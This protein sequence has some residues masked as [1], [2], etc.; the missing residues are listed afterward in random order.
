VDASGHEARVTVQTQDSLIEGRIH[1]GYKGRVSDLLNEE[2]RFLIL[3]DAVV[4]PRGEGEEAEH[5]DTLILRKGEIK[6][7][8]PFD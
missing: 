3:V 1:L 2:A 6:H 8:I 7:V 5:Y 4:K